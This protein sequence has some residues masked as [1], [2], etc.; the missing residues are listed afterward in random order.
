M[1]INYLK[2]DLSL[3]VK[4]MPFKHYYLGSIPKGLKNILLFKFIEKN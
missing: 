2:R 3:T 1:S 4:H